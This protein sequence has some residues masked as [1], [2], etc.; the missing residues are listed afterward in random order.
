[1]VDQSLTQHQIAYVID[2]IIAKDLYGGIKMTNAGLNLSPA[3]IAGNTVPSGWRRRDVCTVR[4]YVEKDIV[5]F[6]K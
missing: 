4:F 3:Q 6:Q 1:M 5:H 2:K